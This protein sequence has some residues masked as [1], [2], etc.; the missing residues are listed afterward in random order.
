MKIR[1]AIAIVATYVVAVLVALAVPVTQLRTVETV[2]EKCCCP[3]PNNCHCPHDK[4]GST[5]PQ[6]RNCHRISH[7]VMAPELPAF[8]APD[9]AL[10]APVIRV[11]EMPVIAY[12]APHPAPAAR[13]PEAPS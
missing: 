6:M 4:G 11:I 13:R 7:D 1:R 10:A 8:G 3:D 5:E 2:T 9:L 12:A